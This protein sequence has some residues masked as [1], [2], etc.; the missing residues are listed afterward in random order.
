[1][2]GKGFWK[3][4][5]QEGRSSDGEIS[6]SYLA[7]AGLGILAFWLWHQRNLKRKLIT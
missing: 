7:V 3:A 2:G 6:I 4:V 5:S 1:M